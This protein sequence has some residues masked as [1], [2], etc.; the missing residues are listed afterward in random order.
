MTSLTLPAA[1]ALVD[2]LILD[3]ARERGLTEA[4][5]RVAYD[6]ANGAQAGDVAACGPNRVDAPQ[7]DGATEP[8]GQRVMWDGGA[9]WL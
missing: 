8:G 1:L 7:V 6:P 5:V 3:L 4:Q 9:G 2:R